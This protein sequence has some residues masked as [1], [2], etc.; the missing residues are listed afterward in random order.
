MKEISFVGADIELVSCLSTANIKISFF[1]PHVWLDGV[2]SAILLD[3]LRVC[4]FM[5]ICA[6]VRIKGDRLCVCLSTHMYVCVCVCIQHD[7]GTN[8]WRSMRNSTRARVLCKTV[9][10]RG[11]HTSSRVWFSV[12]RVCMCNRRMVCACARGWINDSRSCPRGCV[13]A[14][15]YSDLPFRS[16]VNGDTPDIAMGQS[17]SRTLTTIAVKSCSWI[18]KHPHY[19]DF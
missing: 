6:C 1:P 17:T 9:C 10:V 7:I 12:Y 11:V 3:D 5:C 4:P 18:K 16:L 15:F 2:W 19:L 13:Q 14:S 8:V